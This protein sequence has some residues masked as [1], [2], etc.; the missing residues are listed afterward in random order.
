[1]E[2]TGGSIISGLN[3]LPIHETWEDVT[4]ATIRSKV[5]TR[6]DFEKN[7]RDSLGDLATDLSEKDFL[8]QE[9]A[10]S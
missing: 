8:A 7:V 3:S 6:G 1:M 4:A 2:S 9:V 5:S 10:A